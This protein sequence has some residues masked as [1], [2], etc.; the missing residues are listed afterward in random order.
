MEFF[1]YVHRNIKKT[2]IFVNK[3][4]DVSRCHFRYYGC[5]L[6][7]AWRTT[8]KSWEYILIKQSKI[9]AADVAA[10]FFYEAASK[11]I[12]IALLLVACAGIFCTLMCN[13]AFDPVHQCCPECLQHIAQGA[14]ITLYISHKR[15]Y[16]V[17]F[18]V[19]SKPR[20]FVLDSI[21]C[22]IFIMLYAE[23]SVY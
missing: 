13:R 9:L 18:Y 5:Y 2:R 17:I 1:R 20:F 15:D 12:W 7:D 11:W 6:S 16:G 4:A 22:L 14:S 3:K 10:Y 23:L 21:K 8:D 19:K